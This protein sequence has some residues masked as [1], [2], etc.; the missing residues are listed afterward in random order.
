[1]LLPSNQD[2]MPVQTRVRTDLPFQPCARLRGA[3][4]RVILSGP[5]DGRKTADGWQERRSGRRS[6]WEE[7][8]AF[9]TD[10]ECDCK[11]AKACSAAKAHPRQAERGCYGSPGDT[12]PSMRHWRGP[13]INSDNHRGWEWWVMVTLQNSDSLCNWLCILTQELKP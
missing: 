9:R 6:G 11:G 4:C 3:L 1:M 5:Q 10:W 2:D 12:R 7:Q 13:L 8:K